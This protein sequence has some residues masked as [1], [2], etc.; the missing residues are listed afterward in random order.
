[1]VLGLHLGPRLVAEGQVGKIS[2]RAK[3]K[4]VEHICGQM[5]LTAR[6]AP[7][8]ELFPEAPQPAGDPGHTGADDE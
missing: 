5:M 2:A 3:A 6:A 1:V 4:A 7:P 8:P